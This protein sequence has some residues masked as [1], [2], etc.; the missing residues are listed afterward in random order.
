MVT[1]KGAVWGSDHWM[2]ISIRL[3]TVLYHST[4]SNHR[5]GTRVAKTA[6]VLQW[7]MPHSSVKKRE[8]L[9][10]AKSATRFFCAHRSRNSHLKRQTEQGNT[11]IHH[12]SMRMYSWF[13]DL[14]SHDGADL[15]KVRLLRSHLRAEQRHI[16]HF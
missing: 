3:G 8:G 5:S 11:S 14:I 12:Y 7:R 13:N 6:R 9:E 16:L 4:A 10:V 2:E 1:N 15:V